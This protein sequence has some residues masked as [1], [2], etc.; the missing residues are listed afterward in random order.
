MKQFLDF[1]YFQ[2]VAKTGSIR[3]VA[4]KLSITS[5]ALNRRILA[6][7]AELDEKLFERQATGVRLSVVG[8]LFLHHVQKQIADL[9]RVKSQISDLSGIRRG[10][11]NIACSQALLTSFFPEQIAKFRGQHPA[12]TFS[13]YLRD[14]KATE[15]TL[16][17][18]SVDLA[19]VFEPVHMNELQV[20]I[21]KE[22]QLYAIMP[23]DHELAEKEEL[24]LSDCTNYP[25]ALPTSEYGVRKILDFKAN[26]SRL[27]LSPAVESD[28]FEFLRNHV[29]NEG[30]ITFQIEIGLPQIL[31][32][33]G[34][35]AV[36]LSK[37]DMVAGSMY[38]IQKKA[39][40]CLRSLLVLQSN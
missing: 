40:H 5:T 35:V 7:E 39:V 12:V 30:C 20:L 31:K 11:I 29:I 17:D 3:K 22:Q 8:E 36:P 16:L 23:I 6:M 33:I 37:A 13:L 10:H 4:D 34:L 21:C 24:K 2:V 19:I 32:E 18:N 15:E 38:L 28:S 27:D 14:R 9:E 25:L 1:R 26:W